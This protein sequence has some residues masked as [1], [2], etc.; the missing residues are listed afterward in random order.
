MLAAAKSRPLQL[1]TLGHS[2]PAIDLPNVH[3]TH[4]GYISSDRMKAIIYSAA[5]LFLHMAPVDNLPN[6]VAEAFACGT[7]VVAHATGGVPEMVKAGQ[8]GWLAD[9]FDAES[10]AAALDTALCAVQSGNPLR[11]TCRQFA[12]D[13]FDLARQSA[14]YLALFQTLAN[15]RE[16]L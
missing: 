1:V 4:F 5:D 3:H 12:Q 14:Q 11:Q 6:T 16:N 7:P 2:P 8:T 13:H 15:R 10:F 9:R